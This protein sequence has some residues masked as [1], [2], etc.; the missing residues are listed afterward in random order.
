LFTVMSKYEDNN[1]LIKQAY[2]E[3]L[4][5]Q[6]EEV[7]MREALDRIEH[8][9]IVIQHTDRPTPFSFPIMVDRL[10]E[11]LT[12]EKLDDRIQKMIKQYGNAD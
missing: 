9:K 8:Q 10:R 4:T 1:L 6:L 11:Q 3:V 7:R 5:Y 2:Q 12:S